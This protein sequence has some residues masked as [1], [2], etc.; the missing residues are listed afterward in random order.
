MKV[1]VLG[2][3]GLEYNLVERWDL[4]NLKQEVYGKIDVPIGKSS[5]HPYTPEVWGAFLVGKPL[6][7]D[8]NKM[9]HPYM[10]AL[11]FLRFLRKYIRVSLGV[12]NKLKNLRNHVKNNLRKWGYLE[13][14][15]LGVFGIP[16]NKKTFLDLTKSKAINVP[17]YDHD[18]YTFY[19]IHLFNIG[20]FS[21]K[22][23][24][25]TFKAIYEAKKNMILKE[26]E[27]TENVDVVFAYLHFP[28][29]LEHFGYKNQ[30]LIKHHYFDLDRFVS[31]LKQKIGESTVFII[32][33]DHG[34][35]LKEGTHTDYGFYSSNL[36]LNP[37]PRKITDFY[38][39]ILAR[40]SSSSS[41]VH[42][43]KKC[44]RKLVSRIPS[45]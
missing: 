20:L 16:L 36:K 21:K 18:G 25:E 8:L 4:R 44:T 13:E 45:L 37:K 34:F 26:I 14:Y 17:F 30:L 32:V 31:I 43:C 3:D 15:G 9:K 41:S 28:D 33:S 29:M 19:V 11:R 22:M 10:I 6:I 5:G 38:K 23:V 7:V 35:N 39:L 24:I 1:F 42:I 2:L 27:N 12:G 40:T